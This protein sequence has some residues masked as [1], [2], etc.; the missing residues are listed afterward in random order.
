MQGAGLLTAPQ[1]AMLQAPLG[2][3]IP[4]IGSGSVRNRSPVTPWP[5]LRACDTTK[6]LGGWQPLIYFPGDAGQI[7]M[8]SIWNGIEAADVLPVIGAITSLLSGLVQVFWPP[9]GP[10]VS[11]LI[12][13]AISSTVKT[14]LQGTLD[15]LKESLTNFN[16]LVLNWQTDCAN[17]GTNS[18]TCGNDAVN[19]GKAWQSMFVNS[20]PV[21]EPQFRLSGYEVELL[22]LYAQYMNL[23]L[24]FLREGA[25]AANY[26]W[27]PGSALA[28]LP[29]EAI[30]AALNESD[31]RRFIGYVKAT[32]EMGLNQQPQATDMATW[33]TRNRYIREMTL[34]VLD[35]K[36][37]WKYLDPGAYPNGFPGFKLTRMI[38]SDPL[39]DTRDTPFP[40]PDYADGPLQNLTV[41][42]DRDPFVPWHF[43]KGFQFTGGPTS[44]PAVTS[45][46]MG[47]PPV[48]GTVR[49]DLDVRPGSTRGPIVTA[50]GWMRYLTVNIYDRP[51]LATLELIFANGSAQTFSAKDVNYNCFG[52]PAGIWR[53]IHY[54]DQVVASVMATGELIG[55]TRWANMIV[56]GFRYPDSYYPSG[57]AINAGTGRCM[58]APSTSGGVVDSP[59]TSTADKFWTYYSPFRELRV[60]GGTQCLEAPSTVA[61]TQLKTRPCNHGSSQ[62]WTLN[63]SAGGGTITGV[64]SGLVVGSSGGL[65]QLQNNT[66][67]ANQKWKTFNHVQGPVHAVGAGKCLGVSSLSNGTPVQIYTC[68]GLTPTQTWVYSPSMQ[69]LS[70]PGWKQCLTAVG[71]TM[72]SRVEINGC[73]GEAS[74]QWREDATT[75]AITHV[76]SGL[77]LDVL[78]GKT[79]DGSPVGLMCLA[80]PNCWGPLSSSEQQWTWPMN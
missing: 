10:D 15:G 48:S 5:P 18:S 55:T 31:T 1:G 53:S 57:E 51:V 68:N 34:N 52:C 43:I 2:E 35:F 29:A 11:T 58:T 30:Q 59:C 61:G 40:T 47:A 16:K 78:G 63:P 22:P 9:N 65:I 19:V 73:T 26:W 60:W 77:V 39:G 64:Q 12:S 28:G 23:Y 37:M 75:R 20:F 69:T 3:I 4:R 67:A 17:Y 62:Q 66:G 38:Y 32:Y 6:G 27:T 33:T 13:S 80:G 74:Q 24:A 45:P 8:V 46:I 76:Q 7:I 70:F 21:W 14:Q 79:A 41:F 56:F 44:G 25:V 54:E 49:T 36:E 42:T 72:G 71:T 50:Q